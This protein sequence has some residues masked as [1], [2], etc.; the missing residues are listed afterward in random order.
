MNYPL[1]RDA[2]LSQLHFEVR[3]VDE[4]DEVVVKGRAVDA[5]D[6]Q[7]LLVRLERYVEGYLQKEYNEREQDDDES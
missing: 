1:Y 2:K 3:I 5:D 4:D 6:A 7:G